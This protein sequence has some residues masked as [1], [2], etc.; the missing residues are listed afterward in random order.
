MSQ[1]S[2]EKNEVQQKTKVVLG[3]HFIVVAGHSWNRAVCV[4][5]S[6]AIQTTQFI[7]NKLDTV[8]RVEWDHE[9]NVNPTHA[10]FF[11]EGNELVPHII[12]GFFQATMGIAKQAPNSIELSDNRKGDSE[13][14]RAERAA[15]KLTETKSEADSAD[16]KTVYLERA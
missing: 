13:A 10:V 6:V 4:A 12:S 7:A 9:N 3:D 15:A 8:A 1:A 2:P 16:G 11:E 5:M 14:L